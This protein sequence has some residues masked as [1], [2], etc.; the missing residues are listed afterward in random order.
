MITNKNQNGKEGEML[1]S[2]SFASEGD[3]LSRYFFIHPDEVFF[4]SGDLKNFFQGEGLFKQVA[5]IIHQ[6]LTK[7]E[8]FHHQRPKSNF[9]LQT[10]HSFLKKKAGVRNACLWI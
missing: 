5:V 8:N 4:T 7:R 6:L 9:P 2:P 3:D 1:L 10:P